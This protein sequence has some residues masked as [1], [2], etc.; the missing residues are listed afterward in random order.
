MGL[1]VIARQ[2]MTFAKFYII[3][4]V[5]KTTDCPNDGVSDQLKVCCLKSPGNLLLKSM[6]CNWNDYID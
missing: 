3:G 5:K 1:N 4:Q 2:F 6:V